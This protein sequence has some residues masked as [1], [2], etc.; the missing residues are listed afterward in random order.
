RNQWSDRVKNVE[1][2]LFPNYVFCKFD[3]TERMPILTIPG[4][5]AI[6][7]FGKNLIPVDESELNALRAVLKSG[8]HYEPWPFLEVGQRVRIEHGALAGTEG[9]VLMMKNQC[10]LVVSITMLQRSVAAELDR[11]CLSPIVQSNLKTQS[12]TTMALTGT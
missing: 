4:V 5:N 6:V 1:L 10:R 7:G 2:P 3:A 9:I 12:R 11:D 8:T